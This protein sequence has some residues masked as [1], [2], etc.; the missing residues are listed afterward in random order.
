M[1]G[2]GIKEIGVLSDQFKKGSSRLL[3]MVLL[4]I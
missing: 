4:D 3:E 2:A 1:R